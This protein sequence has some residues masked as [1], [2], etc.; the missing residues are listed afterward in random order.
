MNLDE[1][2]T[3]NPK[4]VT[5]ENKTL[6]EEQK[7]LAIRLEEIIKVEPTASAEFEPEKRTKNLA[8]IDTLWSENPAVQGWRESNL[9]CR[10]LLEGNPRPL[11]GGGRH[12]AANISR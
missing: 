1:F 7:K 4:D 6:Y 3:L 11:D 10:P 5:E 2:Y 12:R 8:Q 9:I